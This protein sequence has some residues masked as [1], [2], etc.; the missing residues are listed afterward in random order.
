MPLGHAI[1]CGDGLIPVINLVFYSFLTKLI[2]G[3][4]V[5]I[6]DKNAIALLIAK[7]DAIEKTGVKAKNMRSRPRSSL[8]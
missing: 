6:A 1:L 8:D 7:I 4:L 3:E 2:E 5:G